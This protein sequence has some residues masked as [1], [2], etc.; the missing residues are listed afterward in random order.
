MGEIDWNAIHHVESAA[1]TMS[2]AASRAEDAA[3]RI[4]VLLEDG[5]GG[6]GLRLIELLEAD[7]DAQAQRIAELEAQIAAARKALEIAAKLPALTA[8]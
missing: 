2:S 5:Y 3:H 4:A 1:S 6:N 7:R 8:K